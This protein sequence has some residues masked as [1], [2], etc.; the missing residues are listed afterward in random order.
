VAAR[1]AKGYWQ[2]GGQPVKAVFACARHVHAA[3]DL[4]RS[5]TGQSASAARPDLARSET[6]QSA[7]AA[8]LDLA[9]SETGQSEKGEK[10]EKSE[11]VSVII[12]VTCIAA[13][14]PDLVARAFAAGAGEVQFIGCP[15]EDCANREGNAI[16][17]ARLDRK[18]PPR[19]AAP[20]AGAAVTSDWL[21]PADF[22]LALGAE[23]PRPHQSLASADDFVVSRR[24]WRRLAPAAGLLA[25]IMLGV[26]ALNRVP[27]QPYTADQARVE[28]FLR[29]R[30]GAPLAGQ[31]AVMAAPAAADAARLV[32]ISD[33]TP[34]LDITY[35]SGASRP[36]EAFEQIEL[37][38]GSQQLR[39]E[40]YEGD[41]AQPQVIFDQTVALAGRQVLSLRFNDARV[42]GD[43]GAGARLFADTRGGT[44]AG[45]RICH[46]LQPGVKLV[47][48][49]LA[50]VG[51]AA[52][53]RVPGLSA[54]AYIRQSLT[55]PDAH[56]VDGYRAGQMP[57]DYLKRLSAAQVEDLVAYLLT[58]R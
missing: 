21:S 51:A 39:V 32:F 19:V 24:T 26:V 28:I 29:H 16:M 34:R 56:I 47:G 33:E 55:A 27:F 18:R 17:Q 23:G 8:S 41:A 13:A 25:A 1:V 50:G 31:T 44:G 54:E 42:A 57:P 30:L 37:S 3:P 45:C 52:A 36:I 22:A 11:R 40:L 10:S 58:L 9:R 6:G 35:R 20:A 4:A 38:A 14:H 46:S 2:A 5:E 49:S 12:P 15:P 53:T 43:P 7:R 48:P